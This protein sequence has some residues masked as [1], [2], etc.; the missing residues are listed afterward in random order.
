M[1][2]YSRYVSDLI[3]VSRESGQFF[4]AIFGNPASN[5][6]Q[7]NHVR[8]LSPSSPQIAEFCSL[9]F[10]F[11]LFLCLTMVKADHVW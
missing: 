5:N 4:K 11:I 9:I 8:L 1:E 2:V 7:D 6:Q 3:W 10:F